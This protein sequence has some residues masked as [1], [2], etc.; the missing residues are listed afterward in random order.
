MR[1]LSDA[2]PLGDPPSPV[3]LAIGVFDGVHRGHAAV[4]GRMLQ[5]ART[6]GAVSV[7]VTFDRHPQA[8]VCPEQAPGMVYP[9]WRR[10]EAIR[11]LGADA[12]LVFPFDAEFSR[13]TAEQFVQRLVGGFGR[14]AG[15]SVGTGF[16]F[17]HGRGGDL[18]L[19]E[20]LG[21]AHGFSVVGLPPLEVAGGIVSSTRVR[22]LVASGDF[23]GAG[24]LL[25][26]PYALAGEVVVGD[27]LGRQLGFPTANLEVNGLVLPP[28][29]VYA[30]VATGPEV[31]R[32]AAVNIGRRPTVASGGAPV[33][34]VEAH[35][36]GF[37]GDLYGR[38]LEL[39][40][41]DWLREERAFPSRGALVEQI[42]G[43]VAKVAEWAGNKG[44][45]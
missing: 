13:Q 9:L 4:I 37:D 43:D 3:C 44:L 7:V 17:G 42:R 34:R 8:V 45:P 24:S 33:L 39:E 26:R 32:A 41:G 11:G 31:R 23:A 15:V 6:G 35:L 2:V 1:V 19:L 10:L 29:G 27:R 20:H 38:R 30:A 28:S 16:V 12:A 22:E 14:L 18:A 25:G 21:R 40:M 5:E 36:L